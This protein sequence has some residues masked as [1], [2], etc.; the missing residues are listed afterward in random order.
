MDKRVWKVIIEDR[1]A[2][3]GMASHPLFGFLVAGVLS[4]F[5]QVDAA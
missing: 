5:P 1:R 2:R 3:N 4:A